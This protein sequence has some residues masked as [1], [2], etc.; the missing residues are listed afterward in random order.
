M[1][2]QSLTGSL[3]CDGRRGLRV[4]GPEAIVHVVRVRVR[5]VLRVL[6]CGRGG[7][8]RVCDV[9]HGHVC[10]KQQAWQQQWHACWNGRGKAARRGGGRGLARAWGCAA[11]G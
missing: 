10:G 3:D 9:Q 2:A 1:A 6:V 11:R 5:R 7:W 8:S 4:R